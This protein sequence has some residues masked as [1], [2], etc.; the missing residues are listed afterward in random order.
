MGDRE[1]DVVVV[2]GGIF[3]VAT[4]WE[5]AARGLSVALLERGDFCGATSANSFKMVHGG[6]RYLQH[7]DLPRIRESCGERSS[8]LRIAPHLVRPLP[9]LTPTYPGLMRGKT[10]MRA[11]L[12]LYDLLTLDR[13]RGI[14]DEINHIPPGR[15]LSRAECL[16]LFPQL[17]SKELTGAALFHD[18][19][20]YNPTRL[21]MCFVRSAVEAGADVANYVEVRRFLRESDRITGVACTDLLSGTDI[22]IRGRVV[23]NAAGAWAGPLLDEVQGVRL[24]PS[25]VFSRDACFVVPRRLGQDVALAIQ[26]ATEDPDAVLSRGARHL[27]LV[28]WREFTLVGVWHVVYEGDPDKV[29]VTDEDLEGFLQE[30]NGAL[31]GLG[32]RLDDVHLWNAGLVLFGENR[33][34]AK[35]LS[36]GKRSLI[37]DHAK[38][39]RLEGLIT[40]VGVRYTTARSVAERVIDRA[41]RKLGHRPTKSETDRT[42]VFGG[43]F[44]TFDRLVR[45]AT[46]GSDNPLGEELAVPLLRNYGSRYGDVLRQSNGSPELLEPLDGSTTLRAEILHAVREEM[47]V[48]LADVVFRRTDLGTGENPGTASLRA[49]TDLM[50]QELGWDGARIDREVEDV[51]SRYLKSS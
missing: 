28:P 1:Y 34:G 14:S 21:A 33:P 36:Y 31:P 40:M 11:A 6:I 7:A 18:G 48:K 29:T 51:R 39:D 35:D 47:A 32:L 15:I 23:V 38:D 13:N 5:A 41:F 10:A 30:V 45:E 46:T 2:G 22:E 25:P 37:V 49:C 24:N 9:I 42:P 26:G 8:L 16:D 3:G 12:K 19:Q 44:E 43:D 50:A 27:F 17:D 20:M 4:A